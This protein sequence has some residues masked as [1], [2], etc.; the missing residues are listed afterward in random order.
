MTIEHAMLVHTM[1]VFAAAEAG[2]VPHEIRSASDAIN[3]FRAA[4]M[5]RP[6]RPGAEHLAAAYLDAVCE[7]LR[8]IVHAAD[9]LSA[10]HKY[11]LEL[12]ALATCAEDPQ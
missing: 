5:S 8:G 2:T 4:W 10:L 7:A 6:I 1:L 11:R 9:A 12:D 3:D